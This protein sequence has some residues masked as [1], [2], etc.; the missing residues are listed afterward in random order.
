[1]AV[2]REPL[3]T[4]DDLRVRFGT[5]RGLVYAVNGISF[6]IAPGETLGI[7]GESGCG[8]SVTSLALLGILARNGRVTKGTA[9][10]GGR[11]L[12]VADG[13]AAARGPRP[14]DRDDLPGPDDLAQP[15]ADHRPADPR[16]ARDALRDGARAG[17]QARD[18]AARP[19]RDPER[20]DAPEGLSAPV[21]RR[22]AAAGDDRDGAGR[23]AE[24]PDR[25]RADHCARRHDPGAD[26]RAAQVARRRAGHGADPDHARP[27]R[28]RRHVRARQRHVR[29]HVHGDRAAPT[30]SS[31]GRATRTRSACSRACRGSTPAGARS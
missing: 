22:D 14:R 2:A 31:R 21:L 10:F 25:R 7:V 15:G 23:R 3:L 12:L 1:M 20:E 19:G 17:R 6:D 4:V 8:K 9:M 30:G 5:E 29:R 26:P 28:R 27:R 13:R 24:A 16:G 18:R 11:D